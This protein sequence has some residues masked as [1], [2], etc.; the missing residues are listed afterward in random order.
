M[1]PRGKVLLDFLLATTSLPVTLRLRST[2]D[3]NCLLRLVGVGG[4]LGDLGDQHEAGVER[5]G[6]HE[7]LAEARAVGPP[8]VPVH[9]QVVREEPDRGGRA[10]RRPGP[11]TYAR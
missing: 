8:G 6:E 3:E 1:K 7:D 2:G 5:H 9:G 11:G 10:R 4:P